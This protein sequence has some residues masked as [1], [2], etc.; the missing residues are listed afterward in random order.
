MAKIDSLLSRA[1]EVRDATL[2]KENTALRVGSL[3]VDLIQTI[4]AVLPREILE[5]SGISVAASA[6]DVTISYKK[7]LNDGSAG[8]GRITIPAVTETGA[9]VITPALLAQIREGLTDISE[10]I[11]AAGNAQTSANT[12]NT[13]AANNTALIKQL[14]ENLQIV[15]W[16][17]KSI[18]AGTA[19]PDSVK[20]KMRRVNA[21]SSE[22]D[23]RE[24]VLLPGA[25]EEAAGAMTAQHVKD[26]AALKND[27][28]EV[29]L[30]DHIEQSNIAANTSKA[31][32][33]ASADG[34]KVVYCRARERFLFGVPA[35]ADSTELTYYNDWEGSERYGTVDSKGVKPAEGKLFIDLAEANGNLLDI[36]IFREGA[37]R[38]TGGSLYDYINNTA[39]ALSVLEGKIGKANGLAPLD[40]SA[41]VPE[42]HL[43]DK[44]F[45]VLTFGGID[46]SLYDLEAGSAAATPEDAN[47][48]LVYSSVRDRF[49]LRVRETV[50]GGGISTNPPK[51]YGWFNGAER[52]GTPDQDGIVP[53]ENKLYLDLY[54]GGVYYW[55]DLMLRKTDL[56]VTA[57]VDSLENKIGEANG[58]A[59]L[60]ANTMIPAEHIPATFRNVAHF[61]EVIDR[62]PGAVSPGTAPGAVGDDEVDVVFCE[63]S[64]RFLFRHTPADGLGRSAYFYKIDGWQKLGESA[65]QNGV[66]P[67]AGKLYVN[68]KQGDALYWHGNALRP[69]RPAIKE[70]D[71]IHT[72]IA[73]TGTAGQSVQL[74]LTEAARKSLFCDLFNAAAGSAGYAKFTNGVWDCKLNGLT[75]SYNEAVV[76]YNVTN[77]SPATEGFCNARIRTNIWNDRLTYGHGPADDR[78]PVM[79]FHGCV[80]IEV[81]RFNA[82]VSDPRLMFDSCKK[83]TKVIG[84]FIGDEGWPKNPMPELF[85]H[86]PLIT[87][88]KL[89]RLQNDVSFANNP[90]IDLDSF[91]YMVTNRVSTNTNVYTITV[92]ADV[93]AKLTGDTTNEAAAA[94]TADELSQW[95][96]LLTKAAGKHIAFASA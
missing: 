7:I 59:P 42:K 1:S 55:Y 84:G 13:T 91:T 70:S 77:G 56:E 51:Y 45:G 92:H 68:D 23:E 53:Y 78:C 95:Q 73:N 12:A 76:I 65:D 10:A 6:S 67:S 60:D 86:S 20:A 16:I 89:H 82:W 54:E 44:V 48:S 27:A 66:I 80:N 37:L 75:L 11:R 57:R 2:E 79:L 58:L 93:Y 90:L 5:A 36:Y 88:F 61:A 25:T 19:A 31:P 39:Q 15:D 33:S 22:E 85:P 71:D 81:I 9:G 34:C 24:I 43:P 52:Y 72:T 35:E 50:S 14:Q 87:S 41:L 94:L 18:S 8:T 62:K 63:A 29:I 96:A 74:N 49:V 4:T 26:L 47:A 30:F 40:A 69:L 28:F 38:H 3:F 21:W 17:L 46:D 32:L 83:L 64:K